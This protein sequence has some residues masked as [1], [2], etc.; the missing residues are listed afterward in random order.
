MSENI[1]E[2]GPLV[3]ISF[4]IPISDEFVGHI[5]VTAFDGNYGGSTYWGQLSQVEFGPK[6][7]GLPEELSD[8]LAGMVSPR[9]RTADQAWAAVRIDKAAIANGI[10]AALRKGAYMNRG[11]WRD[12]MLALFDSDYLTNLDADGADLVAQWAIFGEEVYG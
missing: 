5:L 2:D 9:D 8:W 6:Q 11:A 10:E 1:T 4:P 3:T 12:V 7:E